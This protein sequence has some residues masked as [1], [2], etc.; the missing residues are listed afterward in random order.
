MKTGSDNFRQSAI[1][2]II[3][4]MTDRSIEVMIYVPELKV[5][6]FLSSNVDNDLNSFKFK[7]DLIIANRVSMDLRDVS[8]KVFTRDIF[9]EN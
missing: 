7:V 6:K 2:G 4:R 5:N 3:K 1:Q 9:G 8:D